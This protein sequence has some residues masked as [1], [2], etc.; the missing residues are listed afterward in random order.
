MLTPLNRTLVSAAALLCAAF[1]WDR[2]AVLGNVPELL[3]RPLDVLATFV[4][5]LRSDEIF[6][7][8]FDSLKRVAV[9]YF[10]GTAGGIVTGL[11]LGSVRALNDSVGLIVEFLKGV[12]PIAVVPLAIMWLGIGEASKYLVISYIVWIVVGTSTAVGAAEVP[13]LRLRAGA[14]LGLSRVS[15]FTRIVLPSATPFIVAGMRSAIGFAFVAL[16][17]A[18]LIAA[19][20]GIG[21][22]IMDARFALQTKRMICGL[23]TLAIL[24]AGIQVAFDL[25]VGRL[26][27]I[28]RRLV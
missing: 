4:E 25:T 27:F 11:L 24:G 26:K 12:P 1:L 9:G 5:M 23:F 2:A 16:V 10:I 7:A 28:H 20:S 15:I 13:L 14:F 18:E 3:P 19:N 22:I 8:V 17:S 21:Q 6:R